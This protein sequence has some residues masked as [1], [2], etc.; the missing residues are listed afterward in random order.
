MVLEGRATISEGGDDGMDVA[1]GSVRLRVTIE[2]DSQDV[3]SR[4]IEAVRSRGAGAVVDELWPGSVLRDYVVRMLE[5]V[6][7]SEQ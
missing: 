6:A 3:R 7:E 1:R 5:L 4:L 2:Y